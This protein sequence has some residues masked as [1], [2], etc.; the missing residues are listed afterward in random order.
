MQTPRHA[1]QI[2]AH[3]KTSIKDELYVV[4]DAGNSKSCM[5]LSGVLNAP[6]PLTERR[7]L[8][9]Q[10]QPMT[11]SSTGTR[12]RI[13]RYRDGG[14]A[15]AINS[16]SV[17]DDDDDE[18]YDEYGDDYFYINADDDNVRFCTESDDLAG[19]TDDYYFRSH[20]HRQP[21]RPASDHK[22]RNSSG[23]QRYRGRTTA[24]AVS[25]WRSSEQHSGRSGG[26]LAV[27]SEVREAALRRALLLAAVVPLR[28][29]T[30]PSS[31]S[32]LPATPGVAAGAAGTGSVDCDDRSPVMVVGDRSTTTEDEIA[33]PQSNDEE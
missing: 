12:R 23:G 1:S 24:A 29:S 21:T 27:S 26:S 30:S 9:Q 8:Q 19:S 3:T 28:A 7:A 11:W 20:D 22:P 13:R 16:D 6:T 25:R 2:D 31:T 5:S 32:S 15:F 17:D 14:V 18:E 33:Q 4:D 10:Q